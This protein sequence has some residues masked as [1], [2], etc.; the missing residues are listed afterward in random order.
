MADV[1][2]IRVLSV[3]TS[4]VSGGAARAAYRIQEGVRSLGVDSRMFVKNKGSHDPNVHALSEFVP[5]NPIYSALD[6]CAAK[7]KNKIQHYYWNQYSN[8]DTNFKSD[9]RGTRLHGALQSWDYDVLHLHWINNRFV[10]IDDLRKIHKPIVWTLHDTWPFCGICHYFNDCENY[11][12]QCGYCPQLGSNNPNDLSH[13]VWMRKAEVF[14]D[15]DLHIVSPSRW[16]ADCARQSLLFKDCDIR[17]IPNCLDAALFKPTS[18]H[19]VNTKPTILYGAMNAAKDARKGFSFLLAAL[20]ILDNQGF[21]AQVLVFGANQQELPMQFS[22][23][24]VQFVGYI[25]D[26]LQLVSLYNI[27]DVMVV[28]SLNEN[29]SC[30]IMES[31][32]CG[33]PVVAFNIGGNEDMIDHMHNG[34]L[35]REKDSEDLA[36]GI[37]WCYSHNADNELGKAAR[38]KVLNNYTTAKVADLYKS[39]YRSLAKEYKT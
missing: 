29:L 3:C 17:V 39:L 7:V 5:N 11:M 36:K 35:A 10:H 38:D 32:S 26:T 27:A 21:E 30:A 15:L 20:R 24:N 16:M 14:K 19:K 2:N 23:I 13:R 34:Y 31:M 28:P 25:H 4:D 18:H 33:T 9:L 1:D 8:R 37:Q 12:H 22:H 6:W